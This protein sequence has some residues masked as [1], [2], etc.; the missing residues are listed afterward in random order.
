MNF[1][2]FEFSS[3]CMV[4]RAT[5]VDKKCTVSLSTLQVRHCGS[6]LEGSGKG[7]VAEWKG[8]NG[9]DDTQ[10]FHFSVLFLVED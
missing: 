1:R 6:Q 8:R 3:D 2:S 5:M 9:W 7:R 4:F 10:K